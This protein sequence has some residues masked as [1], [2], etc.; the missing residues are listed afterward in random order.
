MAPRQQ[1]ITFQQMREMGVR[2]LL[3][4]RSDYKCS[5]PTAS[6]ATIGPMIRLSDIERLFTC[7]AC[8]KKGADVRPDFTWNGQQPGVV[9][10]YR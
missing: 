8:G 10:G 7:N 5:H 4:Y 2:G 9:M 1:K 3:I 6:A